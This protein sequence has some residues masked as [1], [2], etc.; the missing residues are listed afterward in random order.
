M[1]SQI[2]LLE[3]IS[4]R[5][6]HDLAGPIGAVHN[7]IEFLEEESQ[8]I[9]DKALKIIKSSAEEAISRLKFFR[10]AYGT[11]GDREVYLDSF[12]PQV[13]DFL[14]SSKLKIS[15]DLQEKPIN[16]YIAKAIINLIIIAMGSL[17]YGGVVEIKQLDNGVKLLLKG[18]DFIFNDDTSYLLEGDLSNI[19]LSSANI[20]IYYTH[21]MIEAA[22]AKLFITKRAQELEFLVLNQD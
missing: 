2:K 19:T 5:M 6:F 14:R 4:A 10:Q 16:S 7:S 1:I 8:A 11:I 20:Q 13:E 9:R 15:W 3:L 17:I 22:K 18:K 21:M 12:I